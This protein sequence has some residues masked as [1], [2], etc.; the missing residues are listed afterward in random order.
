MRNRARLVDAATE[1]FHETGAAAPLDLVAARAGLG[2]GTLYR[3]FPDRAA[4]VV[5]VDARQVDLLDELAG[6]TPA[7]DL[8]P[9][10][11]RAIADRPGPR[12]G[13]PRCRAH[14]ARTERRTDHPMR[15]SR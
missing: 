14:A 2:R 11:I 7:A 15:T 8:L 4:L 3:H 13:F 10:L 12:A 6:R 1:V 9:T 5:A